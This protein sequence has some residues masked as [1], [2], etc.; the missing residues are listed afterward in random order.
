MGWTLSSRPT[1]WL[2]VF[3]PTFSRY[4]ITRW[5]G[6]CHTDQL[7]GSLSPHHQPSSAII[8]WAGLCHPDQLPGSLSSHQPFLGRESTKVLDIVIQIS[9]LSHLLLINLLQIENQ[10]IGWIL[11]SILT[12][13]LT[14][15][16]S[17][18][19]KSRINRWAGHCHPDK[20]FAC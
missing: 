4:R 13:W 14:R 10:Q 7:P 19:S 9:F 18:F 16:S 2:T 15:F 17:T 3:S 8:R 12:T 11:S 1:T 5:A 20:L 6:L